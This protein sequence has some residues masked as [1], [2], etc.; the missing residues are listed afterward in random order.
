MILSRE[1]YETKK[2]LALIKERDERREFIAL[3]AESCAKIRK[4]MMKYE[5]N[6]KEF[7]LAEHELKKSEAQLLRNQRLLREALMEMEDK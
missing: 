3:F 6:T 7:Y 4:Q 1:Y 2:K 5:E